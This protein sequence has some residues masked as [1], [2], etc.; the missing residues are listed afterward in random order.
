ME[1][2]WVGSLVVAMSKFSVWSQFSYLCSF[3]F[4]MDYVLSFQ[5]KTTIITYCNKWVFSFAQRNK[6]RKTV[7]STHEIGSIT[8]WTI[9]ST[10][11]EFQLSIR[12]SLVF[13]LT[14]TLTLKTKPYLFFRYR[15]FFFFFPKNTPKK[16]DNLRI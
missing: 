11:F 12:T 16:D 10:P 6:S 4:T 7:Q 9:F 15:V 13:A 8:F 1:R 3:L 5:K 14:A 2:P